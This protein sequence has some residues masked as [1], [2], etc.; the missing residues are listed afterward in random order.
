MQSLPKF[1]EDDIQ[2]V[3]GSQEGQALL[4]LLNRDGGA[5]LRQAANAVKN[6][7]MAKAQEIMRPL[8]ESPGVS[9]LVDKINRK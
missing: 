1:S 6:G 4:R 9:A 3:L 8:M 7:D 5:A 2:R